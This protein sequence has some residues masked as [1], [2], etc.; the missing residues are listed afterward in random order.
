MKQP[1]HPPAPLGSQRT[2]PS[3]LF[4][5]LIVLFIQSPPNAACCSTEVQ[6]LK[7]DF[8]GLVWGSPVAPRWRRFTNWHGGR[9]PILLVRS[10]DGFDMMRAIFVERCLGSWR[11]L[12]KKEQNKPLGSRMVWHLH[13]VLLVV[14]VNGLVSSGK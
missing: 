6:R 5:P 12:R 8:A 3:F 2:S 11:R 13:V 9:C 14:F 4:L 10:G 1:S 7:P